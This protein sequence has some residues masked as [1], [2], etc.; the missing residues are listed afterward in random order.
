MG[1]GF[2]AYRFS[3][4]VG[5]LKNASVRYQVPLSQRSLG[6]GVLGVLGTYNHDIKSWEAKGSTSKT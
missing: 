2:N 3:L 5:A 4:R 6:L 1:S